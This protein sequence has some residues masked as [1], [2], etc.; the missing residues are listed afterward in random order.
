MLVHVVTLNIA[1]CCRRVKCGCVDA[2]AEGRHQDI[3]PLEDE[4][5]ADNLVHISTEN[6][7]CCPPCC[8]SRIT[9]VL[10]LFDNQVLEEKTKERPVDPVLR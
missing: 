7:E 8:Q 2:L 10:P 5:L 3:E 4:L 6:V 1:R 9:D